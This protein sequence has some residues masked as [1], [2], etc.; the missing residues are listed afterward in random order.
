MSDFDLSDFTTCVML[1]RSRS[2]LGI[3]YLFLCMYL[4]IFLDSR[5]SLTVCSFLTVITFG[6][7]NCLSELSSNLM[8]CFSSIN[9][10]N[11]VSTLSCRCIGIRLPFCCIGLSSLL[12]CVLI[13]WCFD[14]PMRTHNCWKLSLNHCLNSWLDSSFPYILRTMCVCYSWINLIPMRGS[15][16][17]P[18]LFTL[19][20][21][22]MMNGAV[23]IFYPPD[24]IV[25]ISLPFGCI[26]SP[27]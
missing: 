19:W 21:S 3:R 5:A 25:A 20:S 1:S 4:L 6:L 2:I 23:C 17:R 24:S 10:F 15:K 13:T 26:D 22:T 14:F 16:F 27:L 9:L 11:S 12:N 18:M 7:M 8:M